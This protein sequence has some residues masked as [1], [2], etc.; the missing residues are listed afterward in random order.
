MLTQGLVSGAVL[1]GEAAAEAAQEFN[2]RGERR[3]SQANEGWSRS[4]ISLAA[5]TIASVA[6]GLGRKRTHSPA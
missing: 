3:G 6:A 1:I 2:K 4:I 5:L